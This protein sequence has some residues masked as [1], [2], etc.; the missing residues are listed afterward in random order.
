MFVIVY[1]S[2][3]NNKESAVSKI[4]N[5]GTDILELI[6]SYHADEVILNFDIEKYNS[7]NPYDAGAFGRGFYDIDLTN[8]DEEYL[9]RIFILE[10]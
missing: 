1:E 4:G 5:L 10:L 6:N 8:I 3:W 7:D 9:G 2:L